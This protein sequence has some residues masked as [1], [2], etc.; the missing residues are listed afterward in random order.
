MSGWMSMGHFIVLAEECK[1][2]SRTLCFTCRGLCSM[3]M[4]FYC[5]KILE[6]DDFM[7]AYIRDIIAVSSYLNSWNNLAKYNLGNLGG[8][9]SFISFTDSYNL[10]YI[11]V[12]VLQWIVC[13]LLVWPVMERSL[14]VTPLVFGALS[15]VNWREFVTWADIDLNPSR[16][17]SHKQL[18]WLKYWYSKGAPIW[19]CTDVDDHSC[20]NSYFLT[21]YVWLQLLVNAV[22]DLQEWQIVWDSTAPLHFPGD[23]RF[24]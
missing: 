8:Q 21:S 17:R 19:Y 11:L 18:Q 23:V 14:M 6:L 3:N 24:G 22:S 20:S 1:K 10:V 2:S 7:L 16:N 4:C 13:Q 9:I 12:F 15:T 5:Q